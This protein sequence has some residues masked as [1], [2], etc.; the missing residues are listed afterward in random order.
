MTEYIGQKIKKGIVWTAA[1]QMIL[2][3]ASFIA[4]IILA[5]LLFPEDFGIFAMAVSISSFIQ[6]LG[7]MGI[8]S[9]LIYTQEDIKECADASFWMSLTVGLA[10]FLLQSAIAPFVAGFYKT[11][12]VTKLMTVS[13][14]GYVMSPFVN[15]HIALLRKNLE[16]KKQNLLEIVSALLAMTIS[17]IFALNGFRVW[18]FVLADI[19]SRPLMIYLYWKYCSWRPSF[20]LRLAYWK[21]VFGYGKHILGMGIFEELKNQ[22]GNIV[23]GRLIGAKMLGFYSFAF[24]K[25]AFPLTEIAFLVGMI[26]QPAFS[27]LEKSNTEF[28]DLF[29]KSNRLVAI[30]VYPIV[31]G[32]VAVAHEFIGV[33]YGSKWLFSVPILKIMLGG[34][35]AQA[36]AYIPWFACIAIGR[37]DIPFK[38]TVIVGLI[39]II[40]MY[41][42]TKYFGITGAAS[43][44]SIV[45]A[46][47][48]PIFVL[49]F[50]KLKKIKLMEFIIS[51]MPGIICSFAMAAILLILKN[52]VLYKINC[53][54]F[55][56]LFILVFVG[57]TFYASFLL[58]F[59]KE[60]RVSLKEFSLDL[61][62]G[63]FA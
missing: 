46:I 42:A 41:F 53:S 15:I 56:N 27:K 4:N 12:M 40:I 32:L 24:Q 28:K 7:N 35:F 13:A 49:V 11:Q 38:F 3:P 51:L 2:R 54:Q 5:R 57:A 43:A 61:I 10:M 50:L 60:V 9:F 6:I 30:L 17:V 63:R 58:I 48:H 23:V 14:L 29:F 31:L 55:V 44:F 22:S 20:D 59:F 34:I 19:L 33:F 52:N 37:P 45:Y 36:L 21:K 26:F 8:T 39:N 1:R 16:F 25:V 62:K 47:A 18:S